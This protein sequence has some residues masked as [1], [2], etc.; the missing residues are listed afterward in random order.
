M[1]DLVLAGIE[2]SQDVQQCDL[3]VVQRP[4]RGVP[5]FEVH[6]QRLGVLDARLEVFKKRVLVACDV[7]GVVFHVSWGDGWFYDGCP[8]ESFDFEFEFGQAFGR[9]ASHFV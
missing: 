2:E 3:L 9:R 1:W 6:P 8:S 7:D 5:R 4:Q